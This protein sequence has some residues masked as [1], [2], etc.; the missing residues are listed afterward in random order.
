MRWSV[1][2]G[3]DISFWYDNWVENK[4]LIELLNLQDV[5]GLDPG[6]K[7]SDFIQDKKWN[8]HKLQQL[9]PNQM[10]LETIIGIPIANAETPDELYW[11]LTS[12]G[13]FSKKSAMSLIQGSSAN[14][15]RPWNYK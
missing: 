3:H 11:G 7:L 4:N 1:G 9:I 13:I 14:I 2:D 15:R 10:I 12:S 8:F 5:A 6:P